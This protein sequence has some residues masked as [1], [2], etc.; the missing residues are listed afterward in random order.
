MNEYMAE[1]DLKEVASVVP[2]PEALAAQLPD[3]TA[4]PESADPAVAQGS[5]NTPQPKAA[6]Q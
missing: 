2:R 4:K 6:T 5:T 1:R 3:E